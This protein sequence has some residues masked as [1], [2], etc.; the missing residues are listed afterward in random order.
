MPPYQSWSTAWQQALYGADG[1][2][3][4]SAPV[5]HFR[6]AAHA[7]PD[8]LARAVLRLAELAGARTVVDLGAG[9][10]ELVTA[11]HRLDPSVALHA[12]DVVARPAGLPPDSG[13]STVQPPGLRGLSLPPD[14]PALVMAWE[15]LD[16]QAHPVLE[17]DQSGRLREVLVD[18]VGRE[19]LGAEPSEVDLSVVPPLVAGRRA[20]AR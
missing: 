15:L 6:T 4:R 18:R 8:L 2:Y 20:A 16:V 14:V 12:A 1:F 3:R 7:A 5:R 10:G 19:R 11:V 17:V 9:R 13:W